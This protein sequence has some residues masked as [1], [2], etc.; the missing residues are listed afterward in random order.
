MCLVLS[1]TDS[2]VSFYSMQKRPDITR[3]LTMID[4]FIS[5]E[6]FLTS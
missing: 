3:P 1:Q 6:I 4:V 2:F 5:L